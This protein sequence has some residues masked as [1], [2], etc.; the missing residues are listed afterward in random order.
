MYYANNTFRYDEFAGRNDMIDNILPD[1]LV[2]FVTDIGSGNAAYI[3]K[4][5]INWM[6]PH[7]AEALWLFPN[8]QHLQLFGICTTLEIWKILGHPMCRLPHEVVDALE[9]HFP[10]ICA[11]G[12]MDLIRSKPI[13]VDLI[14]WPIMRCSCQFCV[15]SLSKFWEEV[16]RDG[17][18]FSELRWRWNR[19][20]GAVMDSLWMINGTL[21]GQ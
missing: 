6:M 14:F 10:S 2:G 19:A 15:V 7:S 18:A 9:H 16:S 21:S 1:G 12:L 8:L 5:S 13:S 11:P 17:E 20:Y 3:S 4:L